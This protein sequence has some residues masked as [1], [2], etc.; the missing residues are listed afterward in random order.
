MKLL[1]ETLVNFK[2][3]R[4]YTF[5]P[6]GGSVAVSGDNGSGKTTLLDGFFWV[7]F[8]RDSSGH[9]DFELKTLDESGAPIPMLEHS[10]EIEIENQGRRRQLKK[11]LSE[12]WVKSRG[13]SAAEFSGHRIA[14]EIDQMPLPKK[15]YDAVIATFA[16]ETLL[17]LLTDPLYFA[18]KLPWQ[19]RRRILLELCGDISE[20]DLIA[21]DARLAELPALLAGRS[22]EDYRRHLAARKQLLNSE[23][24]AIPV[25]VDEAARAMPADEAET[26]PEAEPENE[27]AQAGRLQTLQTANAKQAE[28]LRKL[29]QRRQQAS[30]ELAAAHRSSRDLTEATARLAAQLAEKRAAWN[31]VNSKTF[32]SNS[33]DHC[34]TCGQSI[35]AE[36]AAQTRQKAQAQFAAEQTQQLERLTAEGQA[37]L[38]K[39][40]QQQLALQAIL[41]AMPAQEAALA[42]IDAEVAALQA[43]AVTDPAELAA[44]KL[45]A[46]E[47]ARRQAL[48][49]QRKQAEARIAALHQREQTLAAEYTELERQQF[50]C[51]EFLRV[52]VGLL[53][54]RINGYFRLARFRL[55]EQ[56]VNGALNEVCEVLG[57]ERVPFNSGLNHAAQINT[58]LDIINSLSAHYGLS[59]PIFIDN[60]EA[61]TTLIDTPAQLIRLVVSEGESMLAMQPAAEAFVAAAAAEPADVA[62]KI[63]A[64]PFG[65]AVAGRQEQV[66]VAA[67]PGF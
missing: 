57:P 23:L 19:Q 3:I 63:A 34:P 16:E 5:S 1:R 58:G 39:Q 42:E 11:T 67:G 6:E 2:G 52:K 4:S 20:A 53:E 17:R 47:V 13:A 7:L 29:E 9:C 41:A 14:Y 46:A 49:A 25:R 31:Q 21:G 51:E 50:L 60:A 44:A 55:F 59:A 45:A 54:E 48:A 56:Q 12:C 36:L 62:G 22:I 24:K 35:P 38:G 66:V 64:E 27:A 28:T 10:V 8:D 37:L 26:V 61:V 65:K 30:D 40:Q 43:A 32:V 33:P 15:D 18:A